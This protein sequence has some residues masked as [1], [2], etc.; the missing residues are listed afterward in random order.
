MKRAWAARRGQPKH[1][2][3]P[4]WGPYGHHHDERAQREGHT[5]A[6]CRKCGAQRCFF[7]SN[8]VPFYRVEITAGVTTWA[9]I[10]PPCVR[11]AA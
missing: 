9:S 2:W 5:R 3:N 1:S 8:V 11:R 10:C 7:R 6:T 4:K